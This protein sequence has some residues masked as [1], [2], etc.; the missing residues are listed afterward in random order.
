MNSS[1]KLPLIIA[2]DTPTVMD[3]EKI[4]EKIEGHVSYLKIGHR[5][6]ALGGT[7]FLEGLVKKGF[8]VFLDLKLHDIPNTVSIALEPFLDLGLWSLTLHTAGGRAMLEEAVKTKGKHGSSTLLLGVTVLTSH[9]E[10]SWE[11]VNPGCDLSSAL[12]ER[13]TLSAEAGLDGIVCSPLDLE[14]IKRSG[15][16]DLLRIVPGIRFREGQDDQKR[17][18]RPGQAFR[19]GASYIVMGR[20]VINASNPVDVIEKVWEE[21]REV[22][23]ARDERS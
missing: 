3:A 23:N 13:A 4:L 9:S 7:P 19:N 8:K 10:S 15:G 6:Y 1:R 18:T 2:L 17:I 12:M 11:E 5:L 16:R 20:P 22:Q 21:Y 14:V